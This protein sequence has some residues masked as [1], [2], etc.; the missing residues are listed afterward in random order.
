M[1]VTL[2]YVETTSRVWVTLT[3]DIDLVERIHSLLE[4]IEDKLVPC[5]NF[6]KGEIGVTRF[7]EDNHLYH[8]FIL[9]LDN[10]IHVRFID[11]GNHEVKLAEELFLVPDVVKEFPDLRSLCEARWR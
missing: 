4:A 2:T 7:T 3:E 9:T 8:C 1:K 10:V 11:F 6:S 5:K